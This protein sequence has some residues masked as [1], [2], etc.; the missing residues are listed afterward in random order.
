MIKIITIFLIIAQPFLLI[1]TRLLDFKGF[2]YTLDDF[3]LQKWHK[4]LWMNKKNKVNQSKSFKKLHRTFD[5]PHTYLS[6]ILS[7]Y[8]PFRDWTIKEPEITAESALISDTFADKVLYQ[9]NPHKILP[10]ASLTKLM[11]AVIVMENMNLNDTITISPELLNSYID[12]NEFELGEKISVKNLLYIMLIKSS[13]DAAITLANSKNLPYQEFI[14]LMNEKAKKLKMKNTHFTDPSGYDKNNISTTSDLYK[15]A[16]YILKNH[17]LIFEITK[18]K[19]ISVYS[20][21]KKISHYLNNTNKLL[22]K[23]PNILGGKTGY[24]DK[25]KECMLLIVKKY[26]SDLIFIILKSENRF[27]E[28][29]KLIDWI[30]AAYKF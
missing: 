15:L 17:P 13:N 4:N 8:Y 12:H 16:K 24:T 30:N 20:Q 7:P 25:A 26:N 10:I 21:D 18:I 19:E 1:N 14:N 27:R 23:I 11:T 6:S 9:K 2:V 28:M 22:G 3:L 29:K 5:Q